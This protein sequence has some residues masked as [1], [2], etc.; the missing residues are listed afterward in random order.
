MRIEIPDENGKL[1]N[2]L[3]R[4]RWQDTVWIPR[5]GGRVVFRSRFPDF[6]GTWVN[7]CHILLHEDNGMMQVV[8]GTPF[9]DEAN[10][11]TADEVAT[12]GFDP[13][14][15]TNRLYPPPSPGE[16]Y[17]RS[18]AF[19]DSNH[20]SGQKFPLPSYFDDEGN[21][22]EEKIPVPKLP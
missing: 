22:I 18:L 19:V 9:A 8:Q 11:T 14:G 21:L 15:R 10:Y 5:S 16:M 17:R 3:E 12:G 13:P 2:I 4:P 20:D 1:V 6:V 7:H